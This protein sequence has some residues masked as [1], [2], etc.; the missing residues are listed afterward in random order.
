MD[1][2]MRCGSLSSAL[3]ECR[4]APALPRLSPVPNRQA[5]DP[6]LSADLAAVLITEGLAHVCLVGSSTTLIRAKVRR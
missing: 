4:V 2:G 5:T 6:S 3:C 1:G